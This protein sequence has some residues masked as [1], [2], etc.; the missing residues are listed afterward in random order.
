M[1][2]VVA[3]LVTR[4]AKAIGFAPISSS[5]WWWPRIREPYTGAWQRN[6]EWTADTVLAY[7]AVYA[8][9][10]LV[11]SDIGKLRPRVVVS[12]ANDIW[13][14]TVSPVYSPVLRRPNR[15]QNHIQ[16]KEWYITSKLVHGNAYVLKERAQRGAVVALYPL[17]PC[18]VRIL[19]SPDGSV[20]Y[21]LAAD[22][23][24][25]LEQGSVEVPASEIIHDR[26]NCLWHP[27]VGVS[28][29]FAAGL[30][31]AEGLKIQRNA[32]TFFGNASQPGGILSAP[33]AISD[34]TAQRLKDYWVENFTGDNSGAVA[35]VGDGLK[36][37][38]MRASAADSQ[39]IEQLKWTAEVVCSCFRV[40][41]HKV[42]VGPAPSANNVEA[43]DQQ[44]YSQCL[45]IL[46]EQFEACMDEGLGLDVP[47][48]GQ[49]MGVELDLDGLLRMDTQT[50][51][52]TLADGVNRGLMTPNEARKK[53][54][55]KPLI[56]GDTIY[57]QQ[58]Q[59]SIEALHERDQDRPFAKPPPGAPG[60]SGAQAA[61]TDSDAEAE[62]ASEEEDSAQEP[63]AEEE[64][65][66]R[67][68][69]D[70]IIKG[71]QEAA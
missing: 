41:A 4:V 28:P 50:M 70:T 53:I 52:A 8:C 31:A 46:I 60:A 26:M 66:L 33:G 19:V 57:L 16:F 11:S 43:L 47:I 51:V 48:E 3:K 29:L 49:R 6:D 37:E 22:N 67:E 18:R 63:E 13:T 14:E 68:L 1:L 17:D 40:P 15:Y 59:Y 5:S 42:G 38:P 21:S 23:L 54:N 9:V 61:G 62:D 44:Y 55:S 65:A 7:H 69:A 27:L 32:A 12:D 10:T 39:M 71:L 30:A 25:G 24:A 58:Q 2:P 35:V 20:F 36:F 34:S 56:G 45:Q 64:R